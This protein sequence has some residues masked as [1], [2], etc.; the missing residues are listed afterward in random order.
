MNAVT[1]LPL[2]TTMGEHTHAPAIDGARHIPLQ[3]LRPS[4][5]NPRKGFAPTEL[6]DL[7]DSI[8]LHGLLQ[9]I[10]VREI[11]GA[12]AGEPQYEIIAGH[13]RWHACQL[14][15]VPSV[16]AIVR[17][18][19]DFEVLEVQL[20]E[21]LKRAD[22]HPL[23]EAAGY[24]QLLRKPD[25]LQGYATVAELA[26]R[27][28]KS[29]SYV[30]Q[31]RKLLALGTAARE[32]FLGGHM[33][34]SIAI[35][36]ARLQPADQ[37]EATK[38]IVKGWAGEP[39][40]YKAAA[41]Y[42]HRTFHL[43]LA[44]AIFP[45]ADA[46]LV[47]DAGACP[48]CPKRTG[49]NP[50]L[51]DDVAQHDTC[52]DPAC[53][54]GKEEAHL[55]RVKAAAVAS[56]REVIS[57]A[58]AKKAQ[59]LGKHD[60][61]KGFL[62]LDRVHHTIGDKPLRKLL[63]KKAPEVVLFEDPHTKALKEVVREADALA[64]LKD[65]GVL[66]TSRMP[67]TDATEREAERKA[68][69]ERAWRKAA[70][71]ECVRLAAEPN[72]LFRAR[73]LWTVAATLWGELHADTHK[74]VTQLLGW[75]PLRNSWSSGPGRT[76]AEHIAGLSADQLAQY[77]V[78]VVVAGDTACSTHSADR[79]PKTL[80]QQATALGV[81]VAAIKAEQRLVSK[82]T[83][84]A[85]AAERARKK[86]ATL[87][88]ETALAAALKEAEAKPAAAEQQAS[89]QASKRAAS[90]TTKTPPVRYRNAATGETWSG[91]G[92]QPRWLKAALASG[93]HLADFD[94]TTPSGAATPGLTAKPTVSAAGADPFRS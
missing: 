38:A 36:V 4:P 42:I 22:L 17:Q 3:L 11:D 77:F 69:S 84:D 10:L 86:A 71:A 13:R 81:D 2:S 47:P 16:M 62:E 1:D 75:P 39:M 55:A 91:R 51:F 68:K 58:V 48:A 20:I 32:A 67:T 37:D 90:P 46:T 45:I 43:E 33:P 25:G 78:A 26:T 49:A 80:L 53:Y 40:T 73:L 89:K 21:N 41:D 93:K 79:K 85:K 66:K 7:A 15:G 92:P 59:L 19:S 56:G 27:I 29:E 57:G 14:A 9:P 24:E 52:S 61:P 30:W 28:G 64:V 70:A 63:G 65:A 34:L 60:T 12:K 94:T 31:R 18:M 8:K 74:T 88:P 82:S 35:L 23:E 44:R 54:R 87:T 5:T 76:A 6:Q 83:P 72:D 50:Q